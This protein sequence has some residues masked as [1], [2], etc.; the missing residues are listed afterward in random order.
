MSEREEASPPVLSGA[1][2]V[3]T[4]RGPRSIADERRVAADRSRDSIRKKMQ[5]KN[6]LLESRLAEVALRLHRRVCACV[7][8]TSPRN[9]S[10]PGSRRRSGSTLQRCR[11]PTQ[12]PVSVAVR[13]RLL[14]LT[15]RASQRG[16]A[17]GDQHA[18]HPQ[19][20]GACVRGSALL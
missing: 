13:Q 18:R 14:G 1:A 5:A 16:Q 4:Q 6:K 2:A 19:V 9:R 12:I 17:E 3:C 10:V 8:L 7:H 11:R 20:Q 15:G